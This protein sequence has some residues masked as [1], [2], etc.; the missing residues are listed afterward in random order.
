M[1]FT[2]MCYSYLRQRLSAETASSLL[3]K[4]KSTIE[5]TNK[6]INPLI[7]LSD[8]IFSSG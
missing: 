7:K 5:K 4:K 6:Q 3:E 2:V 8:R 1:T